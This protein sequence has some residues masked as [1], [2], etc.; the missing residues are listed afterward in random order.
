MLH[1]LSLS[2]S[3][4]PALSFKVAP[5]MDQLKFIYPRA[6]ILNVERSIQC[7]S[8]DIRRIILD[9]KYNTRQID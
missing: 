5:Y 2:L 4:L 9:F 6:D 1:S 3:N 7:R 8:K